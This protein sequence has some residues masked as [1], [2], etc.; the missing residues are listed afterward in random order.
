MHARKLTAFGGV[1][2]TQ[3]TLSAFELE[4]FRAMCSVVNYNDTAKFLA[5]KM[6][7]PGITPMDCMGV[8]KRF[9]AATN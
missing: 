5:Q 7:Y 8:T 1:H 6:R 4:T 9:M 2:V 3:L